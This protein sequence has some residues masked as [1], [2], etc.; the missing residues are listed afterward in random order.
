MSNGGTK[1]GCEAR[2][3][4]SNDIQNSKCQSVAYASLFGQ[5]IMKLALLVVKLNSVDRKTLVPDLGRPLKS[6]ATAFYLKRT[7]KRKK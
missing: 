2:R 1:K 4:L 5:V 3:G 6:R 7:H